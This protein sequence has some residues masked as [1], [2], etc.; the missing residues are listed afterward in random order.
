MMTREEFMKLIEALRNK[1]DTMDV[2]GRVS[3]KDSSGMEMFF[4]HRADLGPS[5]HYLGVKFEGKQL[6]GVWANRP[7]LA[8]DSFLRE[9]YNHVERELRKESPPPQLYHKH[10]LLRAEVKNSKP[11]DL[12]GLKKWIR[13]VVVDQGMEIVI[14]PHVHYVE[15]VGNKGPTGGAHI[16]T[17]HFAFHIWEE[18]GLIQADLYTC[19]TLDI[20]AFIKSFDVFEPTKIEYSVIDRE[21]SIKFIEGRTL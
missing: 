14:G 11:F 1:V 5:N 18:I 10:I 8:D 19:G 7:T 20:D 6:G 21:H 4:L 17:S 2:G 12:N 3:V 13:G 16:K 9:L 15:D